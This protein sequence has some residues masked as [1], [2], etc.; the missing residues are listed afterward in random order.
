MRSGAARGR[1]AELNSLGGKLAH[2]CDGR[3]GRAGGHPHRGV[4][5]AVTASLVGASSGMAAAGAL[6]QSAGVPAAFALVGTAGSLAALAAVMGSH[7]L[8]SAAQHGDVL[9]VS[10]E[11]G[12]MEV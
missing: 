6:V 12:C 4:F 5:V 10:G 2:L 7:R 11:A 1:D 9:T 3:R 8:P